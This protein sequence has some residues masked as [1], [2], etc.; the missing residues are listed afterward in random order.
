[1][2]KSCFTEHFRIRASV[3]Q[4]SEPRKAISLSMTTPILI[5]DDYNTMIRILRNLLW[6]IGFSQIDE[7]LDA[8]TAL[9]KMRAKRYGMVIADAHMAPMSGLDLLAHVRADERMRDTPFVVMTRDAR[10]GEEAE[11][12]GGASAHIVKPFTARILQACIE[13]LLSAP[14]QMA[15]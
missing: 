8:R 5:V 13:P 12:R 1:M 2:I 3:R 15:V 7:A 9:S 4:L 14:L 10:E 6:R 11:L